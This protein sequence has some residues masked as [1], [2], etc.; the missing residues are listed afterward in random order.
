MTAH[1]FKDEAHKLVDQLPD[2]AGWQELAYR[3][4]GRADIEGG[5]QDSAAG[6]VT[7]VEDVLKEFGFDDAE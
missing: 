7:P 6:R 2:T 4:A 3:A 5:L 1:V